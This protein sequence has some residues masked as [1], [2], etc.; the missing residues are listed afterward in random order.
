M[1]LENTENWVMVGYQWSFSAAIRSL[2]R[3]LLS[4]DF[5]AIRRAKTLVFWP[6]DYAYFS[7]NDW[8]G[9]RQ[10]PGGEDINDHLLNNAMAHFLHNL[11]YLCGDEIEGSARIIS[12]RACLSRAY[13]IETFDTA[14]LDLETPT[15]INIRFYGSQVTRTAKGPLFVIECE[16]A[17]IY[18]GE[19][20]NE[21]VAVFTDG[22]TKNYGDP[23][24]CDQFY[25]LSYAVNACHEKKSPICPPSAAFSQTEVIDALSKL[26]SIHSFDESRIVKT[27]DRLYVEG[28]SYSL[29]VSYQQGVLP[30]RVGLGQGSIEQEFEIK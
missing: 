28:L 29:F 11:L 27:K 10:H 25:K 9:K 17:V 23:D 2:K 30:G 21:V 18:Y 15:G 24:E 19:L 22:H 6:R 7:R 20:S 5:G 16:K 1:R 3:D 12:G 26:Q 8:A 14:V 4:A 13:N